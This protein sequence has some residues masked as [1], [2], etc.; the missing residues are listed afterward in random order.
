VSWLKLLSLIAFVVALTAT[1]ASSD[2]GAKASAERGEVP[3][4]SPT[5]PDDGFDDDVPD[6]TLP[7]SLLAAPTPILAGRA[8]P[9]TCSTP[10]TS[11]HASRI[12]RPPIRVLA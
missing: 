11:D 9:E 5:I 8:L 2:R 7:P 4:G 12:F 6:L 10:T 3:T 1:Q